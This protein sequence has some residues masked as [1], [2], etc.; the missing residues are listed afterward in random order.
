MTYSDN[1]MKDQMDSMNFIDSLNLPDYLGKIPM[2]ASGGSAFGKVLYPPMS[3]LTFISKQRKIPWYFH[4][5]L[6]AFIL[7]A[8]GYKGRTASDYVKSLH[9]L[10]SKHL[11]K[12]DYSE[13]DLYGGSLIIS[14]EIIN[15]VMENLLE[16]VGRTDNYKAGNYIIYRSISNRVNEWFHVN[17]KVFGFQREYYERLLLPEVTSYKVNVLMRRIGRKYD[18]KAR[19]KRKK[20]SDVIVKNFRRLAIESRKRVNTYDRFYTA[21]VAAEKEA[22]EKRQFI[23]DYSYVEN[24]RVIKLRLIHIL[25]LSDIAKAHTE[26]LNELRTSI[27]AIDALPLAYNSKNYYVELVDVQ[28]D[29][30]LWFAEMAAHGALNT[31]VALTTHVRS[32][33]FKSYDY[34]PGQFHFPYISRIRYDGVARGFAEAVGV[35]TK[36]IFISPHELRLQLYMG[37][38]A[39]DFMMNSGAR[40]NEVLQISADTKCLKIAHITPQDGKTLEKGIVMLMPKG[41]DDPAKYYI[42]LHTLEFIF[43]TYAVITDNYRIFDGVD[44]VPSVPPNK[45][46][47]KSDHLADSP[48]VF[49]V[50][51]SH[52]DSLGLMTMVRVLVHDMNLTFTGED[53]KRKNLALTAHLL[54][55]AFA[56]YAVHSEKVPIDI[57]AKILNQK[58][59]DVTRY[60][61]EPTPSV[62]VKHHQSITNSLFEDVDLDDLVA[63]ST[64]QSQD[65]YK[66]ALNKSGALTEVLG[67]TC[68]FQGHCAAKTA[69][70]GC[71]AK[72]PD[73]TKRG[74]VQRKLEWARSEIEYNQ[75]NGL[76]AEVRKCEV[77]I[78]NC[79]NEL[80]EMDEIEQYRTESKAIAKILDSHAAPV[81]WVPS[82]E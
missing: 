79:L 19:A 34:T 64:K 31:P 24:N 37:A 10:L 43:K 54:R 27:K 3:L 12:I 26:C 33:F 52:L 68:V 75:K 13:R 14:P 40:I 18:M 15:S 48:F 59:L 9:R 36:R 44:V 46:N 81:K 30:P 73:P 17:S 7:S 39:I 16:T 61:S 29:S 4:L 56:T 8:S 82:D 77:L 28:N 78:N 45:L 69:C 21:T 55:H 20:D 42:T 63:R 47:H 50:N 1:F 70:I 25:A 41:S 35:A 57:V 74:D 80:S 49:Q 23:H 71:E 58:N 67:G 62:I 51:R 72:V 11:H 38:L 60:Y 2:T 22:I 76:G 6:T 66:D 53:G 32:K 5:I 65:L